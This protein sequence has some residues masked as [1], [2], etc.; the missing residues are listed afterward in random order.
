MGL[1]KDDEL[2]KYVERKDP[3]IIGVEKPADWDSK[4][5]PVQPS[6]IDLHIG[7]IFLPGAKKDESGGESNP[8]TEHILNHGHTAVATTLEEFKLPGNIA[9]IGFPPSSVSSKGILMTNPG[10]IDPGYA[11]RMH[12][13]IINM[14]KKEY[15]LRK[16][17]AIVTV[18]LIELSGLAHMDWLQRRD[19]KAAEPS[20]QETIDLLSAD[21]MD[22]DN[23]AT[24]ISEEAVKRADLRIKKFSVLVP[25]LAALAT[26]LVGGA[27]TLWSAYVK[28]EW[29]EPLAE[30]KK[31]IAVL[32]TNLDLINV[33]T[34]LDEVER[35]LKSTKKSTQSGAA[36]KDEQP[37]SIIL[38]VP[39]NVGPGEKQ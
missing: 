20:I 12:F 5:S 9:G 18:L 7:S 28:P 35:I 10:H 24:K 16:G 8:V 39:I 30:V 13:T 4:N 2:L 36:S 23:R 32:K 37:Q 3:I 26:A 15:S 22:V 17:D 21:F 1:L 38:K 27:F 33:K 11:G 19:K 29:R 6:S 25:I 14:G 31:E 34:R